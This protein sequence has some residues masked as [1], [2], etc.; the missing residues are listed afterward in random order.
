MIRHMLQIVWNR[1]ASNALIILEILV[2]FLVVFAVVAMAIFNWRNYHRPLGYAWEDVW[3]IN[4]RIGDR[5]F[6][7]AERHAAANRTLERLLRELETMA[8]VVRA[9]AGHYPPYTRSSS[10]RNWDTSDGRDIFTEIIEATPEFFEVLDIRIVAGRG[11]EAADAAHP[12]QPVIVNRT[13]A[14]DLFGEGEDP[15]GKTVD[16]GNMKSTETELRVVGMIDDYRKGGELAVPSNMMFEAVWLEPTR[17]PLS[18]LAIRLAPG[19]PAAFEEELSKRLNALAPEWSFSVRSLAAKRDAYLRL[20]LAPLL[21]AAVVAAFLILMV[22]LGLVGVLWQNVTQR[23]LEVGLRRAKGATRPNI[24]WQILGEM[25]MIASLGLVLGTLV[26][27]Q[28]PLMGWL[29][30]LDLSTFG[31]AFAVS[32]VVIYCLAAICSLYPSWL[33]ARIQPAE[34]LH[35]E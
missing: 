34:A 25:L 15:I 6:D 1:K 26:V 17:R 28:V 18:L 2:S 7:A 33:A 35:Y 8:P 19:T 23:T 14:A 4:F 27:V 30:F 5:E 3:Q 31:L 12:W 32:V 16:L 10:S 9:A 13:L 21:A 20:R 11:F 22:A 29:S 24:H